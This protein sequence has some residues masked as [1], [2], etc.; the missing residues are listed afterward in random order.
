MNEVY[1]RQGV[2]T[3]AEAFHV[4]KN[5]EGLGFQ[6]DEEHS[7][8]S[9]KPLDQVDSGFIAFLKFYSEPTLGEDQIKETL[10]KLQEESHQGRNS[11]TLFSVKNK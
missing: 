1:R 5:V 7:Y 11:G 8:H 9:I 6:V 2:K 10:E 4:K 3:L